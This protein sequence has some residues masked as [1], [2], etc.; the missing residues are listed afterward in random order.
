[1][2]KKAKKR[3]PNGTGHIRERSDGKWEG[4]YYYLGE[5]KSCYADTESECR[6]LL[7][8]ILAKIYKGS[9]V[10]ETSIPL[11]SYLYIWH[12]KYTEIRPST[13]KNYETYI[14]NH[15]GASKLGSIPLNRLTLN[16]FKDFFDLKKVSGRLDGKNGGLSP[17]TLQ[18][19]KVMMSE[20]L[21]YAVNHLRILEYNPIS[22]LKL[23]KAVRPKI[24]VLSKKNQSKLENA[25]LTYD[26]TINA[27]MV[28]IDLNT[29]PR[30]GEYCGLM[31]PD[32]SPN[33]EY[34]DIRRTLERL[35]IHWAEQQPNLYTR[36]F[37]NFTKE[38]AKTALYVGP[39]KSEKSERRI[40]LS[41]EI[42]SAFEA[43]E[44]YQKANGLYDPNGFVFRQTNGNPYEPRAYQGLYK[45]IVDAAGIDYVNFHVLRHTFATRANELGIDIPTIGEILGHAQ[46]STTLNMYGHSVDDHKIAAMRKISQN[47]V[48]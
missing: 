28:F 8:S 29:G 11:Y 14:E 21:N 4:Q 33:K 43:V 30:I 19:M 3:A 13:H 6:G 16:D 41:D 36:V 27:L 22:G 44:R 32:F 31:W 45:K 38:G 35:Y 24:N 7:N 37:C 48:G 40:Y 1:M 12:Q 39:P 47:R 34:Y 18:N 25:S 26:K 10:A 46:N 2:N 20:A 17:K 42:I 23:P 9:F 5:H 15:I